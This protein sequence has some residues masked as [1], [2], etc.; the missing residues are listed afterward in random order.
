MSNRKTHTFEFRDLIYILAV[1]VPVAVTW[2]VYTTKINNL[3]DRVIEV[4]AENAT[5]KSS[6]LQLREIIHKIQLE[7]NNNDTNINNLKER[8]QFIID[9]EQL[10]K[11][12]RNRKETHTHE[13]RS[14][15]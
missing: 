3:T 4:R 6:D 9:N 10:E 11:I 1:I 7:V 14:K 13:K 15:S 12:E 2:G 5:M 8:V